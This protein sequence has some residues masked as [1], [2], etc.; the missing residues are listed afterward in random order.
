MIKGVIFDMDGLMIDTEKLLTRF[1]CEAAQFYGWNMTKEHVLGIRSLAAKYAEPHLKGIF[2]DDFNYFDVRTKRIEL[3]NAYIAENGIEKKKGLDELLDY[4]DEVGLK[5]AVA[6][7]TD[8]KRT[9]MYLTSIG[10]YDRFDKIVCGDMIKNGKPAPDIYIT[11]AG[12]LELPCG[13]CMALEDSPNGIRS[14]FTAGCVPVMIPDLSQPDDETA[15][16]MYEK[17]DDLSQVIDVLKKLN[18]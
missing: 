5:K 16:I 3:M 4:L 7:A 13:E 2:G 18:S 11:A 9:K 15:K 10:V 1:W 17:C 6:T 14:A 8:R 12:E